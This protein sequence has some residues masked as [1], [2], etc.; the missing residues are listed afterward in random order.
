MTLKVFTG[1]STP[2]SK[3]I[4]WNN[5]ECL[6]FVFCQYQIIYFVKLYGDQL[7]L[8]RLKT[9]YYVLFRLVLSIKKVELGIRI[10]Q[11][12]ASF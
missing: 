5:K 11:P 10:G 8:K 4:L 7:I 3:L 2:I 12:S 9:W 6:D 1:P